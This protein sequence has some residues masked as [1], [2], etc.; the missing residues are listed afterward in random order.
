MC[1]GA[2]VQFKFS[3]VVIGDVVNAGSDETIRFPRG[4]GVG[5]VVLDAATSEAAR[6]CVA[7]V[8]IFRREK[9]DLWLED[10]G[11]A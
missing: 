11:G 5:V 6:N 1:A 9:P 4:H 10:W 8:E 7:L 2:I 3:R